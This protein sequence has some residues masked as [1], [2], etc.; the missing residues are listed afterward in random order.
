MCLRLHFSLTYAD[1]SEKIAQLS[2][3]ASFFN[4]IPGTQK[5]KEQQAYVDSSTYLH[6]GQVR[7]GYVK[8]RAASIQLAFIANRSYWELSL[9]SGRVLCIGN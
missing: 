2:G 1:V 9:I 5:S 6:L 7:D 8:R 3:N 4:E